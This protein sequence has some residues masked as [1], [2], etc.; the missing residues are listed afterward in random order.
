[1]N[2]TLDEFAAQEP[3]DAQ[4]L[5]PAYRT[6][7]PPQFLIH[8]PQTILAPRNMRDI[9]RDIAVEAIAAGEDWFYRLKFKNKD[10]TITWVEGPS[11]DLTTYVAMRYGAQD[12][13]CWVSGEGPDYIE[14]TARFIDLQTGSAMTRPFRQRKGAS[15]IGGTD[16]GRRDEITFAIGASKA[17]RNCIE[18]ALPTLCNFAFREA[19]SALVNQ[20]E[21]DPERWRKEVSRRIAEMVDIKRVEAV[22]GRVVADWLVPDI[23]KVAAMGKAI[24]EGMATVDET[25]PALKQDHASAKDE[26]DKLSAE[27]SAPPPDKG[28]SE[29]GSTSSPPQE[30]K[31]HAPDDDAGT[32]SSAP[33][34]K[35]PE[36]HTWSPVLRKEATA[37]ML[38]LVANPDLDREARIDALESASADWEDKLDPD[39]LV[40]LIKTCVQ[41]AKGFQTVKE[42]KKVLETIA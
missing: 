33:D 28:E 29:P 1:M 12:T 30:G 24:K 42:A 25:F 22:I 36:T 23:A 40:A 5:V 2:K 26:L 41:V 9:R 14:F 19:K 17:V 34:D 21:G 32:G 27:E 8:G 16:Q 13:D 11:I 39:Y 15:K 4:Q 10:G 7:E 31:T 18:K 38:D 6:H 35:S 3:T 37:K 20:I